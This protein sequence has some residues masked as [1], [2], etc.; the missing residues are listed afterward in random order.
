M[1]LL[2]RW[3][4]QNLTQIAELTAVVLQGKYTS[5][6]RDGGEG[7]REGGEKSIHEGF[8]NERMCVK[9]LPFPPASHPRPTAWLL[10]KQ[11]L[12]EAQKCDEKR[13]KRECVCVCSVV[14]ARNVKKLHYLQIAV[15]LKAVQSLSVCV[16][17]CVWLEGGR[18]EEVMGQK[19]KTVKQEEQQG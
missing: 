2:K 7:R 16:C 15:W 3:V 5:Q 19:L 11:Q 18:C 4:I 12:L 9:W 1:S 17:V 6:M 13:H 14:R 10:W 8:N